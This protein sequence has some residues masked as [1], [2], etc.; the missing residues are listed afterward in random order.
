MIREDGGNALTMVKYH[1]NLAI[2]SLGDLWSRRSGW[3][4]AAAEPP[5]AQVNDKKM[6]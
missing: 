2:R 5:N 6:L 3:T 1:N 4:P